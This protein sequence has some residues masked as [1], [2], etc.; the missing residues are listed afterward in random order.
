MMAGPDP[1][2]DLSQYLFNADMAPLP[3]P[4]RSRRG[5]EPTS[6]PRSPSPDPG[7][8]SP[9]PSRR[10]EGL[11]PES[12]DHILDQL[13]GCVT[14]YE[15]PDDCALKPF[16]RQNPDIRAAIDT[17]C[18]ADDVTK[19]LSRIRKNK[20]DRE[21]KNAG[22]GRRTVREELI[23][24][25]NTQFWLQIHSSRLAS[26]NQRLQEAFDTIVAEKRRMQAKIDALE[27]D[28]MALDLSVTLLEGHLLAARV[29]TE[30]PSSPPPLPTLCIKPEPIRP[31]LSSTT[32]G[33]PEITTSAPIRKSGRGAGKVGFKRS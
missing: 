26:E 8:R 5:W 14:E 23:K 32:S 2:F 33:R 19:L 24:A 9:L 28:K 4:D 18:D 29:G 3:D 30:E 22:A 12:V 27:N 20:K 15:I 7:P 25:S 31:G 21:A 6:P 13:K 11:T 17:V 16:L 10:W 1:F